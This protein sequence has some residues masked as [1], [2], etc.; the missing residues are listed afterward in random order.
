MKKKL[1]VICIITSIIFISNAQEMESRNFYSGH[2]GYA[3]FNNGKYNGVSFSSS[4]IRNC[5]N[6]FSYG[7][8]IINAHGTGNTYKMEAKH[9]NQIATT[10]LDMLVFLKPFKSDKHLFHLGIGLSTKYTSY[11]EILPDDFIYNSGKFYTL[12]EGNATI[13]LLEPVFNIQYYYRLK[14]NIYIGMNLNARDLSFHQKIF[15]LGFGVGF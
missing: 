4:F 2:V 5:N 13:T 12:S 3:T 11:L 14:N 8:N 7:L 10:A 15:S 9:D 1:F 6:F